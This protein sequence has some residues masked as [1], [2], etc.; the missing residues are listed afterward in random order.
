MRSRDFT[1]LSQKMKFVYDNLISKIVQ[2]DR[3]SNA[4]CYGIFLLL[5]MISCK[6]NKEQ[7]IGKS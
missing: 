7:S 3:A 6:P 5:I 4:D 2:M 1:E